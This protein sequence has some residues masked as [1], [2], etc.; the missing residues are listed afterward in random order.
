MGGAP[1]AGMH[2]VAFGAKRAFHSFLRV[3]R[4]PLR[5]WPGLTGARFDMLSAF[6]HGEC[7]RP[8]CVEVRQS[9]LRRTLGVCASVVSRMVRSLERRGWVSRRRDPTDTRT[10]RLSLT[11]DGEQVIRAARRLLLRAM[12]R[13][14]N[15]AICVPERPDRDYRFDALCRFTGFLDAIRFSFDDRATLQYWWWPWPFDE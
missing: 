10:W 3:T 12:Q 8:D 1:G 11:E 6:L 14:V 5:A 13:L 7:R 2:A 9:E 15:D 4:R